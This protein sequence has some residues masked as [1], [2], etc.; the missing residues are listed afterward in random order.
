MHQSSGLAFPLKEGRGTAANRLSKICDR[1]GNLSAKSISIMVWRYTIRALPSCFTAADIMD[2]GDV[3]IDVTEI[4]VGTAK[5]SLS[6]PG[7]AVVDMS[8]ANGTKRRKGVGSFSARRICRRESTQI[9]TALGGAIP[10]SS[11]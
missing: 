1:T 3:S 4:G 9:A 11:H 5:L 7:G 8:M 10:P 2:G 6:S